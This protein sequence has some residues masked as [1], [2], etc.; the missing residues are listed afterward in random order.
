MFGALH[1]AY[2]SDEGHLQKRR[3][4]RHSNPE[5]HGIAGGTDAAVEQDIQLLMDEEQIELMGVQKFDRERHMMDVLQ[6]CQR[7]LQA[8]VKGQLDVQERLRRLEANAGTLPDSPTA[9]PVANRPRPTRRTE[10]CTQMRSEREGT[11]SAPGRRSCTAA[12]RKESAKRIQAAH[13]ARLARDATIQVVLAR[14]KWTTNSDAPKPEPP[15]PLATIDSLSSGLV[16]RDASSSGAK[17]EQ[18]IEE[19]AAQEQAEAPGPERAEP[20]NAAD[21][22]LRRPHE[23]DELALPEK[24]E[25]PAQAELAVPE[26]AEAPAAALSEPSVEKS[27]LMWL[28]AKSNRSMG[29]LFGGSRKSVASSL[30]ST[31]RASTRRG[32]D[33]PPNLASQRSVALVAKALDH[34]QDLDNLLEGLRQM[35]AKAQRAVTKH[36]MR[37]NGSRCAQVASKFVISD[38]S[39]KRQ[40]WDVVM[41]LLVLY[42]AAI[43]PLRVAFSKHFKETAW[44]VADLTI[45]FVFMA[46]VVLNFLTTFVKEGREVRDPGRIAWHYLRTWFVIDFVSA[47]PVELID[48][49][50]SGG[51]VNTATT[52]AKILRM[53]KLLRMVRLSMT[54]ATHFFEVFSSSTKWPLLVRALRLLC[55]L[56]IMW[57]LLSCVYWISEVLLFDNGDAWVVTSAGCYLRPGQ[58][59]PPGVYQRRGAHALAAELRSGVWEDVEWHRFEA[60]T[61]EEWCAGLV[62]DGS[63]VPGEADADVVCDAS[64]P[65]GEDSLLGVSLADAPDGCTT[66]APVAG[67]VAGMARLIASQ[68][69]LSHQYFWSFYWAVSISSG[70][71]L[72]E[73]PERRSSRLVVL[74]IVVL[75]MFITSFVI[76]NVTSFIGQIDRAAALYQERMDRVKDLM[77]QRKVTRPLR[78]RILRYFEY[79]WSLHGHMDEGKLMSELPFSLRLQLT[80]ILH[81]KLF[82]DVPLFQNTDTRIVCLMVQQMRP[83]ISL[84]NEVIIEEGTP[85]KGLFVITKGKCVVTQAVVPTEGEPPPQANSPSLVSSNGASPPWN[86]RSPSN[87]SFGGSDPGHGPPTTS[88]NTSGRSSIWR[89]RCT[90]PFV[91]GGGGGSGG[92]GTRGSHH[93]LRRNFSSQND[94]LHER[95]LTTLIEG[96]FF[97]EV[98]LLTGEPSSASVRSSEYSSLM[99]LLP[100][101][102]NDFMER[103]P[104]LRDEMERCKKEQQRRYELRD[105]NRR[106]SV[107]RAR[108]DA[109]GAPVVVAARRHSLRVIGQVVSK[110]RLTSHRGSCDSNCDEGGSGGEPAGVSQAGS[111]RSQ[112]SRSDTIESP[113][114]DSNTAGESQVAQAGK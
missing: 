8:L 73:D 60:S 80:L 76:G 19:P 42:V 26:K 14:Q 68:L 56:I 66:L 35:R 24:T 78:R 83:M 10:S 88:S 53:F 28:H 55:S 91:G 109:R 41:L 29:N 86:Q 22:G 104:I 11:K 64:A 49:S 107:N 75:G 82:T 12:D 52:A 71:E 15:A 43:V 111:A 59:M 79:A 72:P 96:D 90:P 84:P 34:D 3:E 101:V 45:D 99:V 103:F 32:S 18:Q 100:A 23:L 108:P 27:M 36:Q 113:P 54:K 65:L 102:F 38:D 67:R 89:R 44:K 51:T 57:H 37:L 105:S 114:Q 48:S 77:Q 5:P 47:F 61:V 110:C 30:T 40:A 95:L 112:G 39:R 97:G 106:A 92:S 33:G 81:R 46:D 17:E 31:P 2:S 50:S 93:S 1:R 58:L 87:K 94:A 7:D 6:A 74:S 9:S 62:L 20:T 21:A 4:R 25:A 98:S 85:A 63:L 69:T 13:R 70:F 16:A